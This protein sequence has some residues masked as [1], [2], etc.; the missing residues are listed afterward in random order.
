[1]TTIRKK[2][3]AVG[4]GAIGKTCLLVVFANGEFPKKYIPTVFD[5]YVAELECDGKRVDLHLWDT[6]GQ[7]DY[8]RLRPLSYPDTDVLLICYSVDSHD[9]MEN[10]EEKW[11]PEVRHFCPGIP[12]VL[13]ALKTDRREDEALV[14][15]M[16]K[17]KTKPISEEK[18]QALAEKLNAAAYRECS[19]MQNEGVREVFETATRCAFKRKRNLA[20][21]CNLM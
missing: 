15:E 1:M 6:A 14:K 20:K 9:S 3:V 7:E 2:L 12:F 16:A 17:V 18:G 11:L 8:D 4:D 13:V 21:K 19:A 10:A 5:N